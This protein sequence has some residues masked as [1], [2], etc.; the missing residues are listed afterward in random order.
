MD[1]GQI[2]WKGRTVEDVMDGSVINSA[3]RTERGV[4]STNLCVGT[5]E[6]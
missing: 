1:D 6:A 5:Y 2:C 4:G 3:V